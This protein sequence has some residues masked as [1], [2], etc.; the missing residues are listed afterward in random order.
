MKAVKWMAG[1]V[2]ATALLGGLA[3]WLER[4]ARP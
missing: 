3:L 1:I 2:A 4:R